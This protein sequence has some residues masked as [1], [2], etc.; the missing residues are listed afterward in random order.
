MVAKSVIPGLRYEADFLSRKEETD[1]LGQVASGTWSDGFGRRVQE[2]GFP[3]DYSRRTVDH[4]FSELPTWLCALADR[5]KRSRLLNFEPN[6]AIVSE[7]LPGQ[8]IAAHCDARCFGETI[9]LVSLDSAVTMRF[10]RN[11]DELTHQLYLRPRSVLVLAGESRSDWKHE[12]PR[13]KSDIV[14]GR[15]TPRGRRVSVTFR[16]V[17]V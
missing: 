13:R 2:F 11:A 9:I 15:K 6:Q 4:S 14:N 17:R 10:V 5:L 8:G 7:Y 3:Y 1:L 16:Q 12:I